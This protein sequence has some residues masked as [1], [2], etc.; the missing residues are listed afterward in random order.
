MPEIRQLSACFAVTGQLHPDD[1]PALAA[2]GF[3]TIVN[4]RPDGEEAGQPR[5]AE[6][7]REAARLG[8]GYRHIPVRPGQ[9]G[10]DGARQLADAIAAAGGPVLAFCRTGNRSADLWKLSEGLPG[11]AGRP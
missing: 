4:N 8:L 1:L 2:Q 6:I 5:S 11:A 3:R 10:E 7:A 9:V